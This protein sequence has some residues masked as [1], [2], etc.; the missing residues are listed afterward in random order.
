MLGR[1]ELLRDGASIPLTRPKCRMLLA[2]LVS[3]FPEGVSL[4]TVSDALWPEAD[5]AKAM[6]SLRV[7]ATHLRAAL[8]PDDALPRR[9]GRYVLDVDRAGI[10]VIRFTDA[11]ATGRELAAAGEPAEAITWFERALAEWRGE[12]YADFVDVDAFREARGA[13][14]DA[15]LDLLEG[16]ATALLDH[17]CPDEVTRLLP[18]TVDTHPMREGLAACLMLGLFRTGR[19]QDALGVFGRV[20]DALGEELGIPP[21]NTLAALA[22]AIVVAPETLMP[23]RPSVPARRVTRQRARHAFVGRTAERRALEATWARAQAGTPQL[24]LVRG[25]AGIGKSTIVMRFGED[26][27]PD[28]D[29]VMGYCD[30]DAGEAYQPFPQLVRSVLA[31]APLTDTPPSVLGELARLAPDLAGQLPVPDEPPE[32]GAG[33]QRLFDAVASV[34]AHANRPRILLVE[35]LHWA[36]PDAIAL[37]RHVLN[38][39]SGQ[40]MVVGTYRPDLVAGD[41]AFGRAL[42]RG[43]LSRPDHALSLDAMTSDEISA[44]IDVLA[45]A[46]HRAHWQASLDEL[47]DVSAGHPLR[48]VEILKHLEL[49]PDTPI[50]DVAPDDVVDLV[51]RRLAASSPVAQT[52]LRAAAAVGRQFPLGLVAATSGCSV[53]DT[54]GA[55]ETAIEDGL[56]VE[57]ETLDDFVFAHPLYRNAVYT[58][59]TKARR[60]RL[61][62]RIGEEY[63]ADLES[64]RPSASWSDAA[65]HLGLARPLGDAMQA[66]EAARRAGDDAAAR[67]AHDEA[68]DWY[69]DALDAA[70]A[71]VDPVVRAHTRLRHGIAL[72]RIGQVE[73][74]RAELLELASVARELGDIDLIVQATDAA[75]PSSGVLQ[76][77]LAERLAGSVDASLAA[78]PDDD[79]RKV[80]LYRASIIARMYHDRAAMQE[81]FRRA[82]ELAARSDDPEIRHA[83][84]VLRHPVS[85]GEVDAPRLALCRESL[86]HALRHGLVVAEGWDRRR[87]LNE[88]VRAGELDE[89]DA[90]L[91]AMRVR[92]DE[93]SIPAH[94]YWVAALTA[95]RELMRSCTPETGELVNAAAVL[96]ARLGIADSAGTVVLQTF[97]LR[98][99]QGRSREMTQGLSSATADDPAIAAGSGLL[100]MSFAE[101][102]R[103][104]AARA[105]LD[106]IVA[107]RLL[108]PR[109]NFRL[110]GLALFAGAAACCGSATQRAVLRDQLEPLADQFLVF[111]TGGAV[112]GTGHHWLARIE[113]ALGDDTAAR[114]HLSRAAEICYKAGAT[115]WEQRA[116]DELRASATG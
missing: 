52:V 27:A 86:E 57:G 9:T 69:A 31:T 85:E 6:N 51:R 75:C 16:Y 38:Q 2:Y 71:E 13:L 58:T 56:V 26:K 98:Y 81:P 49:N 102:G 80:K 67:Y 94:L 5:P 34:L 104:D 43:R 74:A 60:A 17:D 45:P 35:D 4:G 3:R 109:D 72:D 114:E 95:L 62:L 37:L 41:N 91:A 84:L 42:G 93:T 99:Q 78:V 10:D 82:Q 87:L 25:A 29:V 33:R 48:V 65:R 79:P 54:L 32:P 106:R 23:R 92:A 44:L 15:R 63:V 88:L 18:A 53:P 1:F 68:V 39:A 111:G 7:H 64:V 70:P 105:I 14:E 22:E 8:E 40:V 50:A 28:A 47:V 115:Y 61:H 96:G 20:K 97:A 66:F 112:F 89:F 24:V 116:H 107:D 90:Q 46:S 110:G 55:L 19:Q 73:A 100:A 21:G 76:H 30:P 103:V 77:D 101:A 11:A 83:A 12:P 36:R 59:M 108:L 113:R